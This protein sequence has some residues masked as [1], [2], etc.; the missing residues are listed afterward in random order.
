MVDLVPLGALFGLGAP[1]LDLVI[2]GLRVSVKE[3]AEDMKTL[4]FR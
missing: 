2:L 4:I 1:E 3:I